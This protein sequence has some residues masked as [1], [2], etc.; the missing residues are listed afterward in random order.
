[1]SGCPGGRLARLQL[2]CFQLG[3]TCGLLGHDDEHEYDNDLD[4]S[5]D[6]CSDSDEDNLLRMIG[7]S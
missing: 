3:A 2:S 1:M 6:L 5:A 4:M 7:D